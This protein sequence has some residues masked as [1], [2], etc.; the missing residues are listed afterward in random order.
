MAIC[1]DVACVASHAEPGDMGRRFFYDIGK[2]SV[3]V[4]AILPVGIVEDVS[5]MKIDPA[6]LVEVPPQSRLPVTS[7]DNASIKCYVLESSVAF[8][9]QQIVPSSVGPISNS[10]VGDLVVLFEVRMNRTTF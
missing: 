6:V 10:V 9:L 2:C 8:V 1:V 5:Y 7:A 3:A 4:V